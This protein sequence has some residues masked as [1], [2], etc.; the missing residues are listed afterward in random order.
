MLACLILS[1]FC[2]ISG[3]LEVHPFS[4]LLKLAEGGT[5]ISDNRDDLALPELKTVRIFAEF[6]GLTALSAALATSCE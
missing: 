5:S 6:S 4:M 1:A 2:G 3:Y